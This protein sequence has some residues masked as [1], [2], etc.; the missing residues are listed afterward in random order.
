MLLLM[1]MLM[2]L[3]LILLLMLLLRLT[4]MQ[5]LMLLLLITITIMLLMRMLMHTSMERISN[6]FSISVAQEYW[7]Y[8][9]HWSSPSSSGYSR[10]G[11]ALGLAMGMTSLGVL[12]WAKRHHP[13]ATIICSSAMTWTSRPTTADNHIDAAYSLRTQYKNKLSIQ[14]AYC[15]HYQ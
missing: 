4:L 15:S 13:R 3:R 2:Q 9:I 14:G 10:L 1:L 6:W 8:C 11:T 12:M 7:R 5:M